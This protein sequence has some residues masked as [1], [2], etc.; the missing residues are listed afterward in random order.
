MFH[1]DTR[2]LCWYKPHKGL[3]EDIWTQGLFHQWG[4]ELGPIEGDDA[5]SVGIVEHA[6]YHDVMTVTPERISF[7]TA[8]P[9]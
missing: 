7:G 9:E 6:V 4:F 8:R 1:L 5:F 2:I 3:L